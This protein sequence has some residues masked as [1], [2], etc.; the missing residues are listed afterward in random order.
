MI[1][2]LIDLAEKGIMPDFL[3]RSGIKRMQKER[4]LWA[5]SRTVSEVEAQQQN[6]VDEMKKSSKA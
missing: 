6:W 3:I 5:K 1:K 4:L 2:T